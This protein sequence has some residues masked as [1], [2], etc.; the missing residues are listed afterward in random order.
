MNWNCFRWVI[1][2]KLTNEFALFYLKANN[3]IWFLTLVTC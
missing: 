1:A 3:Q 2:K